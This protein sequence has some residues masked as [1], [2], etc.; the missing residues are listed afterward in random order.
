MCYNAYR[1]K[2]RALDPLQME[3]QAVLSHHVCDGTKIGL[4]KEQPMLFTA[5]PYFSAPN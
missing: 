1:V 3:L 5:E 2:K 4:L